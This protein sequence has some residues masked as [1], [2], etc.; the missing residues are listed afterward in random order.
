MRTWASRSLLSRALHGILT[1]LVLIG[2]GQFSPH[3]SMACFLPQPRLQS[4]KAHPCV[5]MGRWKVPQNLPCSTKYF[6]SRNNIY[7]YWCIIKDLSPSRTPAW[8][9]H[10]SG[11]ASAHH[12]RIMT[13]LNERLAISLAQ[14]RHLQ[15][16]GRRVFHSSE[17]TRTHRERLLRSGFL[18]TIMK[19]WLILSSPDA[20]V[21]DAT[22]WF[23]SF[24]EFCECYAKERFGSQ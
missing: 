8:M 11:H 15:K 5:R 13:T 22:S 3:V 12:G 2:C 17:L 16:S 1:S 23:A 9:L 4:H 14:L 19:G 21:N 18:R 24:W 6:Q 20:D 7:L 10:R